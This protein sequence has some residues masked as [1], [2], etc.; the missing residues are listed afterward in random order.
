VHTAAVH[1]SPRQGPPEAPARRPK[2]PAFQEDDQ[3]SAGGS[4]DE[5]QP[6]LKSAAI[7]RWVPPMGMGALGA[8]D[9][10]PTGSEGGAVLV[11]LEVGRAKAG[12]PGK[13]GPPSEAG[14]SEGGGSQ[15]TG[16]NLSTESGGTGLVWLVSSGWMC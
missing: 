1:A 16:R 15:G 11:Q 5:Q 8:A 13:K 4:D 3:Q 7:D 10:P 14:G 2:G 6:L 9:E 12:L